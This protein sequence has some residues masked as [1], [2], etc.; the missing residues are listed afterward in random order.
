MAIKTFDGVV[1]DGDIFA[2]YMQEKEYVPTEIMA[3][4]I[5]VPDQ[6]LNKIATD[7]NVG[8]IPVFPTASSLTDALNYD[9]QT[10]NTPNTVG[11]TSQTYMAVARQT[12]W[13]ETVFARYLAGRTPFQNL[14][15]NLVA[16]YWRL[17]W[18]KTLL[19]TVEGVLGVSAMSS[20]VIDGG[21]LANVSSMFEVITDAKQA[22]LGDHAGDFGLMYMHS[23]LYNE[24]YKQQIIEFRK[25][26][27]PNAMRTAYRDVELATV[28][29]CIILQD[30][31][32]VTTGQSTVYNCYL[33]GMGSILE[34]TKATPRPYYMD[35][36]PETLGGIEKLY[37]NGA[38]IFHPN[39]FSINI[40]N[41]AT[42]SPTNTEL[43]TAANWSLVVNHKNA[44]FAKITFTA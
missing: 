41:I 13:K 8:V 35:Y 25:Y 18:K 16:P 37:T 19:S 17:Q 39:G 21:S 12:A 9:G 26:T 23:K 15:D 44:P 5:L 38:R 40:S 1:F 10:N 6:R 30:D 32:C 33:L 14:A 36:D 7:G 3:S 2:E 11:D 34:G 28:G 42:E 4:G 20:H 31:A 24:L 22:A 43:A 27:V 29:G